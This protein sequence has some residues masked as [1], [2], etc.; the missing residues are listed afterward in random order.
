MHS[1]C[2]FQNRTTIVL[3]CLAGAEVP[4]PPDAFVYKSHVLHSRIFALN[5][6]LK[7]H[8][9][10]QNDLGT[11][12][13]LLSLLAPKKDSSNLDD[14]AAL[15]C[16]CGRHKNHKT[17]TLWSCHVQYK[18]STELAMLGRRPPDLTITSS[19]H[20]SCGIFPRRRV[21]TSKLMSLCA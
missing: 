5:F 4:Q 20:L 13:C 19:L 11:T 15:L 14:S 8:L 1:L 18:T 10:H 2:C 3:C 7:L 12:T 16:L 6:S 17:N 9:F 21:F